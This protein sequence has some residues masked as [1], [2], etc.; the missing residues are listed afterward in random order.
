[1]GL[2]S[3]LLFYGLSRAAARAVPSPV[4]L[5]WHGRSGAIIH[6]NMATDAL[7]TGRSC[8]RGDWPLAADPRT[9]GRSL[10]GGACPDTDAWVDAVAAG[11]MEY[12]ILVAKHNCGFVT[13]PTAV[14]L[15]DGRAYG[16][17][18]ANSSAPAGCDVIARFVASCAARGIRPA[19]Y[20][21]FMTNM[22]LNVE[23]GLVSN[24][25]LMPGQELV[26]QS[27]FFEIALGH[28]GELWRRA[29]LLEIWADGG[30]PPPLSPLI[31][32]LHAQLQP[33]AAVYNGYPTFNDSAVRWIG[34][35]GGPAPD[36]TW[37]SGSC[38]MGN[39]GHGPI[40]K[41]GD[42]DSPLWCPAE[43]DSTLQGGEVWWWHPPAGLN[44]LAALVD[45][46]HASRGRNS[47]WVLGL[48]PA[49]N[50]TLAPTHVALL[51]QLG[52][53]L[54]ACYGAAPAASGAMAASA[55]QL[56]VAPAGG[57]SARVNRVRLRE[58]QTDGQIVRNY[59]V[60]ATLV[61][62][63][64][65]LVANGTSVGAGKIDVFAQA[66]EVTSVTL[67]TDS[68]PRGLVLELFECD[69]PQR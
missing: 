42:P 1:M 27:E 38:E 16:Y 46:Y 20:Y 49:P 18:I 39:A 15:P 25:T 22:Y 5:A 45:T 40:P 64:S 21:S 2:L 8:G 68:A 19:F 4:Q 9:F 52:A 55:T 3:V 23:G 17:S 6:Y 26:T 53:W 65:V 34:I 31:R 50:G 28:L 11:G 57:G 51:E 14:T 12:A 61:G 48:S 41:G 69:E 66:V 29:P 36:P 67:V 44:S 58:D 59:N 60:T 43:V 32:A 37:S 13:W 63:T 56:T 35:G 10:A 7:Q 62:G 33:A 47:N 54:G 24:E 30:I